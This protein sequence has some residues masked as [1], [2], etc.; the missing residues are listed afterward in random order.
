M[1]HVAN[2]R[3][4]VGVCSTCAAP[5]YEYDV[6]PCSSCWQRAHDV[7]ERLNPPVTSS[8]RPLSLSDLNSFMKDV[9][10]LPAAKSIVSSIETLKKYEELAKI[11]GRPFTVPIK[12]R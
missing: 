7:A 12:V 11:E 10:G 8:K 6:D 3:R 4:C 5:L 9:Y 1:S 2:S